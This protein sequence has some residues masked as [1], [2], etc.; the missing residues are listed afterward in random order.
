MNKKTQMA[1]VINLISIANMDGIITDNEKQLLYN[2]ANSLGL[3]DTEF[4][5]CVNFAQ[6]SPDRVYFEVPQTDEEKTY[7]LKNLTTMMMIDGQIH[8]NEKQYIKIVAEK[9]GYDGDKALEILI[10]SVKEDF[11]RL[12]N[13]GSTKAKADPPT[14][15][16]GTSENEMSDEQFKAETQKRIALGKE[17]LM[18]HDIC[19]AF[20]YLLIPAHVDA[21][22]LKL[23]LMITNTRNRLFLLTQNQVALLKEYA[24]RGYAVAKYAYGCYLEALRP[25]DDALQTANQYFKEAA[26]AGMTDAI[27]K[28]SLLYRAGHY[29]AIDRTDI[30]RMIDEAGEKGSDL[31]L[32]YQLKKLIY[33]L[34]ETE[35]EPQKAINAF[36]AGFG[37]TNSDDISQV[38]PAYYSLIGEAY[39]ELGDNENAEKY[40]MKAIN[41][42]YN[43]A[44]SY[45]CMLHSEN[46]NTDLLKEM[47][48]TMLELGCSQGDPR[49]YLL[50]A[51][52]HMD[53]YQNY[54]EAKKKE[55]S[56][57]IKEDLQTSTN[58]GSDDAPFFMGYAYYEGLYGFEKKYD[59]AW[60]WFIKGSRRDDGDSYSMLAQM[61]IDGNNPFEVS[62]GLVSYCQLMALRNGDDS[63]LEEVVEAYRS[64]QL[65]QYASEI[66]QYYV[67][68]Y[69]KLQNTPAGDD[70]SESAMPDSEEDGRKY[71]AV[72]KTDG[73]ADIYEFDVEH[74]WDDLPKYIN[75]DGLDAVRVQPLYDLSKQMDYE[76]HI[77]G[78]VDRNGLPKG[79]P[80]NTI[81]CK[82]YPGPI[83]GDMILTYETAQYTPLSFTNMEE[84]Q[85]ILAALG[86]QLDNVFFDESNA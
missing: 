51:A 31:A 46:N 33:G 6:Q 23:F 82:L 26:N 38:N 53:E 8:E 43:E 77:T 79:L 84:I 42:G 68:K 50:K 49:C 48:E 72:I 74:C 22:G 5:T 7:C 81:G 11:R 24:E 71:I 27:F 9:F 4:E 41:M 76:G 16:T 13:Q 39:A 15:Q 78:W 47:Y 62:D 10:N 37:G 25:D 52:F 57:S 85:N 65:T 60:N 61:V 45:Y 21:E 70:D 29:G 1:H 83:A 14:K 17:A 55:I 67:P 64:G 40:Y 12:S 66:E 63:Q 54:D 3:N 59:E 75:A 35:A 56:A 2:I 86:A 69:E 44:Y 80:M 19:A 30:Q 58:L 18:K 73:K 32:K 20:D 36:N 28:K 34:D